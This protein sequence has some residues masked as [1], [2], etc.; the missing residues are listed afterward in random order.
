MRSACAL[1]GHPTDEVDAF[2]SALARYARERR[3]G[4]DRSP[5]TAWKCV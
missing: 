4:A 5:E 3:H 2:R 1:V